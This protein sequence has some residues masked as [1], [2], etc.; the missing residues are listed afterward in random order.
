[1]MDLEKN[2]KLDHVKSQKKPF[3]TMFSSISWQILSI[4]DFR[5]MG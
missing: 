1:M 3:L 2:C 4:I 5:T